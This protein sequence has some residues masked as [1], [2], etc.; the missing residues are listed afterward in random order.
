[1]KRNRAILSAGAAFGAFALGG[2]AFAADASV[3][4]ATLTIDAGAACYYAQEQGFFKR[5]GI[6]AQIQAIAS[7][8]AI[9]A[10]VAS[11][12]VDVGFA[13]LV[14]VAAAFTRNLPVT[15]VAPGSV[16]VEALPTNA[17]IVQ[18][19]STIRTGS[20]LNG[21]T[22]ATTTLRNIVQFAAQLWVDKHGGDSSTIHFVEMPFSAMAGA[23]LA[24]RIDAAI[25]AEPFMTDVKG[26][27]RVIAYPMSAIGPRVQ[28]GGWIANASWARAN[29]EAVASFD[30][31]IVKANEWA[32][33]HHVLSAQI[34]AKHSRLDAGVLAKM[35]RA[36]YATRLVPAEMQPAIDVA[37]KYG[38]IAQSI[39]VDRMLFRTSTG[40]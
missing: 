40:S 10:A 31:A 24:G 32:N 13:N 4:I 3:R 2:R 22:M 26:K 25:V 20:D 9:V 23:L 39:P 11:N 8:G 21:K 33:A 19:G 38:A 6:D 35:N 34:L 7:G 18:P 27:T 12:A 30:D 36:T 28:L 1:M 17:L 15:I 14:S 37:A 5:A 29:S 16:D